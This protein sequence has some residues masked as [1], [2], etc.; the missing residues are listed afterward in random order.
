MVEMGTFPCGVL[1]HTEN[2]IINL[3]AYIPRV[4]FNGYVN[5]PRAI[6][7]QLSR[8]FTNF[9]SNLVFFRK[10]IELDLFKFRNLDIL[11]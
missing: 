8:S 7:V 4:L 5:S 10:T 11:A 1:G 9:G 6:Y 3:G 2:I